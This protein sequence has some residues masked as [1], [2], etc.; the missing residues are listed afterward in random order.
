MNYD[1]YPCPGRAFVAMQPNWK[2]M[3]G[4]IFVP[5]S[6]KRPH[7]RVGLCLAVS[8]YPRDRLFPVFVHGKRKMLPSYAMNEHYK[9][10]VN[11][12]V[13]VSNARQVKGWIFEVRLEFLEAV[14]SKTSDVRATEENVNR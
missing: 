5:Q 12:K 8:G 11:Q 14:C 1:P 3:E 7:L 13:I 10:L 9:K 6:A 2:D 4:M